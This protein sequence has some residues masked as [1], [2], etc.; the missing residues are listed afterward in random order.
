MCGLLLPCRRICVWLA[1][2]TVPRVSETKAW[3]IAKVCISTGSSIQ[4]RIRPDATRQSTKRLAVREQCWSH[5]PKCQAARA[6]AYMNLIWVLENEMSMTCTISRRRITRE[7]LK[8]FAIRPC[9]AAAVTKTASS[10]HQWPS[11]VQP[12]S[13]IR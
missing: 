2:W 6:S 10:Q 11:L 4:R 9:N 12:D 5:L 13:Q 3:Q 1:Q 7:H 8:V